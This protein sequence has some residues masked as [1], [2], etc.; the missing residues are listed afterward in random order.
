MSPTWM[1]NVQII[2]EVATHV[3]LSS[4]YIYGNSLQ[5]GSSGETVI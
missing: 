1:K 3:T 5:L 2:G 4:I